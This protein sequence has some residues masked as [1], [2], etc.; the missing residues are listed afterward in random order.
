[1]CPLMMQSRKIYKLLEKIHKF[2]Q[3]D[4]QSELEECVAQLLLRCV[5]MHALIPYNF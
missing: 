5:S 1:M 4:E 2:A 3:K